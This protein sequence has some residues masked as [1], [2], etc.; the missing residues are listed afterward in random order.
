[1]RARVDLR[2]GVG[3]QAVLIDHIRDPAWKPGVPGPIGFPEGAIGVTEEEVRKIVVLGKG[4][5]GFHGVKTGA[6]NLD[7]VLSE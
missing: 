2:E 1:M 7:I 3:D 4:F 5:V 6:E